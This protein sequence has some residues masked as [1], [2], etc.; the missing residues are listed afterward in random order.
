MKQKLGSILLAIF[1]ICSVLLAG[2]GAGASAQTGDTAQGGAAGV[3]QMSVNSTASGSSANSTASAI[4]ITD[5]M[6]KYGSDDAYSEWKDQNP[7]Y[8][9]LN[10][11][12]ATLKGSGAVLSGSDITITAPGVYVFSGKL[13]DGQIVVDCPSDGVVRL[14][15]NGAEINCSDSSAIFV[16]NAEKTVVSLQ[17]GTE[18]TVSDGKAYANVDAE[19]QE[20]NAAIFSKDDLTING[21]GKLTVHGNYNNGITSKDKLKITGGNI[22]IYA[23]DDG[24]MGRDKVLVNAGSITIEAGGDGIKATNDTEADKGFIALEGGTYTIKS[25]DKGIQAVTALLIKGGTFTIDS[26]DD[27][28]H[29][30]NSVTVTGGDIEIAAGDDGIHADMSV[31]IKGG[32]INITKSYEGIEGS[33]ITVADGTIRLVSSD[34]GFNVSGGNDEASGNAGGRGM[35]EFAATNGILEIDG[36][37]VSVNASG[38]GLDS[39]GSVVMKGGTVVVSGPTEN[40]NAALDYNGSFEISGGLLVAAGSAGMA[41]APSD[42][43]SAYSIAMSFSSMQ[44]AGTIIHL[45][46]S[47]G[48]TVATFAPAK[49]YQS[50][51]ISS[52]AL[53][54]GAEY[55]VYTGGTASGTQTDGFYADGTYQ[56]GTKVVSFTISDSVTWLNESG[57]TTANTGFGPGGGQGGRQGGFGGGPGGAGGRQGRP[58]K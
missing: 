30:N 5:D 41:Q 49:G 50:V 55:T 42:S 48:N 28:L 20:P 1:L 56:G 27:A 9:E 43:S 19:T 14:V 47:S 10:G 24:L 16:K 11:T 6:I 2:C 38:D 12:T 32:E 29:S 35:D 53:K 3:A 13:D 40:N 31:L 7:N 25:G 52:P 36:G 46:D 23:V 22:A 39:N 54:K 44:Q 4:V 21:S 34:D 26:G 58:G 57:V 33:F 15:L 45:E 37:F 17:E 18:N 8:I 51:V